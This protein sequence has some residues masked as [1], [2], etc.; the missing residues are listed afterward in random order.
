[1][2]DGGPPHPAIVLR[3]AARDDA[4]ALSRLVVA[5]LRTTKAAD[6]APA[7]IARVAE[8]LSAERLAGMISQA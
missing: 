4:A 5:T 7:V 6:D 8:D 2:S 3:R 1:M